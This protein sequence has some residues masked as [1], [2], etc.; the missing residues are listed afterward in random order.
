[1]QSFL[2]FLVVV[3]F[4]FFCCR[5][6]YAGIFTVFGSGEIHFF[7]AVGGICRHFYCVW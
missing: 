3:K 5:S 7:A 6:G 4:I 2:L 1:M